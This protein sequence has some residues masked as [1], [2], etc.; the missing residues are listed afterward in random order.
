[1]AKKSLAKLAESKAPFPVV[2][3]PTMQDAKVTIQLTPTEMEQIFGERCAEFEPSCCCCWSWAQWDN[4]NQ[5][6]DL[7][8]DKKQLLDL[9]LS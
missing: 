4:N 7:W 2:V 3:L 6:V 1:M 9:I 8:L 5:F